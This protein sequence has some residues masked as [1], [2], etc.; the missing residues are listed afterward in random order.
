[1][2]LTHPNGT[3]K[4]YPLQRL[5]KLYD[6]IDQLEDDMWDEMSEHQHHGAEHTNLWTITEE[7]GT[8]E[9]PDSDSGDDWPDDDYD[10]G[11]EEEDETAVVEVPTVDGDGRAWPDVP[12]GPL[13]V[14]PGLL[15]SDL[16]S[17]MCDGP[18][19]PQAEVA[20]A[21]VTPSAADRLPSPDVPKDA[22]PS[23]DLD[24]DEPESPWKRFDVLPSAPVDHAF[25]T[26]APA[27][28][29]KA[30]LGR[31]T[32]EYRVLAS[33]LPGSSFICCY[34]ALLTIVLWLI[35]FYPCSRVRRPNRSPA[36]ANNWPREY[37]L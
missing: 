28:P 9:P 10:D 6:G 17:S 21:P 2:E 26:S 33:S 22:S 30:F 32:K 36:L 20:P 11:T 15:S 24:S 1:M 35:R 13:E 4:S 7:E 8:S 31:L 23:P 16:I 18:E 3:V 29:S 12:L 25:Y 34:K 19:T 37:A 27:Q 14:V 5:T